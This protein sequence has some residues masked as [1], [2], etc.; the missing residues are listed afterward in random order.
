MY[1][2]L[3]EDDHV[4]HLEPLVLTRAVYDLRVGMMT[5]L[6]A[7][8]RAFGNPTVF[9][10][11]R[12]VVAGITAN[13]NDALNRV[14]AGLDVLFINGRY[15]PEK[16]EILE[17]LRG[18][19]RAGE[20]G[21]LFTQGD[22]LIAAWAPAVKDGVPGSDTVSVETF[23]G[24]R[25]EKVTGARMIGRLW[26]LL[27]E[28]H[29]ALLRDYETLTGGYRMYERT[30]VAMGQ[31]VV[32][33]EPERIYL[34]P[35]VRLAP[36]CILNAEEGPIYIDRE[37]GVAEG[38]V[39]RGPLYLG[40][41]SQA[42]VGA[43]LEGCSI[44]PGCKV[45]GEVHASL[46]HSYSNKAHAGYLGDSYI[47]R[48]CNLGADTNN[49]NLR[50]DYGPVSLYNMHLGR[51]ESTSR[52]FLGLF[53]GDHSKCGIDTMFNTGT[54]VGAAC[55]LFG[56]GYM[57]RFVPSFSWGGPEEGFVPYRLEKALEVARAV[58]RRRDRTLTPAEE[59]MLSCV[60]SQAH[61]SES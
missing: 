39:L 34:A 3:F 60:S 19:A 36:G 46:M 16:G 31:G 61:P 10:Q 22:D 24:F 13:E 14:P 21:T 17:R 1:V 44:G 30:G 2:C 38:A 59:E 50:N 29:R 52:Q 25:E 45:G 54:V 27:D 37:A 58:M 20:P 40:E 49:S 28:L 9:V 26:H 11:A 5:N 4:H 57:P 15:L 48:W 33:S 35:G 32:M 8:R 43:N 42:R 47:G 41:R 18:A 12:R 23:S 51:T 6:N 56:S 7:V 53:M 55:N